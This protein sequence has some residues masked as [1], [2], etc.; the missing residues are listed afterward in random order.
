MSPKRNLND[1][2][3]AEKEDVS[4]KGF[5]G[6]L[7]AVIRRCASESYPELLDKLENKVDAIG[8]AML[9]Y[10]GSANGHL[11]ELRC[12]IKD[13]RVKHQEMQDVIFKWCVIFVSTFDDALPST[14]QN[15]L[16]PNEDKIVWT[17]A[18]DVL[19]KFF[20]RAQETMILL[21]AL[22]IQLKHL[23]S[24]L[25]NMLG[26]VQIDFEFGQYRTA[27]QNI[28]RK[29]KVAKD[30]KKLKTKICDSFKG[31][32]GNQRDMDKVEV[33]MVDEGDPDFNG[34]KRDIEN[35]SKKLKFHIQ[36]AIELASKYIQFSEESKNNMATLT[37]R[38]PSSE[39]IL[40][41][42]ESQEGDDLEKILWELLR[43]CKHY[44]KLRTDSI[45]LR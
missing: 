44:N 17:I 5:I 7:D 30:E 25:E 20:G 37:Y 11:R 27:V 35:L 9:G 12:M 6:S 8:E 31:L 2:G 45:T 43:D 3:T 1:Q 33:M 42:I 34:K 39:N 26:K 38:C 4:L 21:M 16:S 10:E 22:Q 14:Q 24:L 18:A 36:S 29:K 15:G 41:A 19:S 32:C 28:E 40:V 23:K 13:V